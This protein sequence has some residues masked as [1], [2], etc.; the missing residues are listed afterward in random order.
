VLLEVRSEE[1][2]ATGVAARTDD[3]WHPSAGDLI[4]F[5][6]PGLYLGGSGVFF[7]CATSGAAN[8]GAGGAVAG[9]LW[10]GILLVLRNRKVRR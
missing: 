8:S 9:L 10:L 6:D 5:V 4:T 2:G 3:T 7:G 1:V